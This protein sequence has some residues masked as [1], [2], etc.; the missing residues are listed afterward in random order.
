MVAGVRKQRLG[1]VTASVGSP[2]K[3]AF[4][5]ERAEARRWPPT[6]VKVAKEKNNYSTATKCPGSTSAWMTISGPVPGA[7]T[8]LGISPVMSGRSR[9]WR[10]SAMG[11]ASS[12][13]WV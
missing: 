9:R 11:T 10:G 7:Q 2:S 1:L 4:G 3:R 13:R 6:V 5:C 8:G 12:R